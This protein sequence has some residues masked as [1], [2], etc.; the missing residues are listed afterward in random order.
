VDGQV[1]VIKSDI[2]QSAAGQKI[3]SPSMPGMM[4]DLKKMSG[5]ATGDAKLDQSKP[6]LLE[7]RG[8]MHSEMDMSMSMAGQDQPMSMKLNVDA[9]HTSN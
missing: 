5:K 6:F 9:R 1:A 4:V 7:G 3:P 2:V 8:M